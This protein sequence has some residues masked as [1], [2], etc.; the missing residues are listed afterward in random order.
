MDNKNREKQIPGNRKQIYI[1]YKEIK[2]HIAFKFK[3]NSVLQW[4]KVRVRT[5]AGTT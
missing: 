1:K 5:A 3:I 2:K 4:P